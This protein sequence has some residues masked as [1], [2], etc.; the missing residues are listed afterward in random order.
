M[1]DKQEIWSVYSSFEV[2]FK[3]RDFIHNCA[4]PDCAL[5]HLLCILSALLCFRV[6]LPHTNARNL[7]LP[8]VPINMY[9]CE[10]GETEGSASGVGTRWKHD[11]FFPPHSWCVI[12]WL[13]KASIH[14]SNGDNQW[15]LVEYQVL[16]SV[17]VN[18]FALSVRL[19][20]IAYIRLQFPFW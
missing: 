14:I 3:K 18:D 1:W 7:E 11:F 10:S 13:K 17:I 4:S 9:I 19:K 2:F 5:A 12:L 15:K 6:C 16:S 20:V 8:P